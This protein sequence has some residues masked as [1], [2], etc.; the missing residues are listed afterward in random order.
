MTTR[1]IYFNGE[2]KKNILQLSSN[3]M[4]HV[5]RKL[6]FRICEN[7]GADQLRG[8]READQGLCFR[9]IDNTIPLLPMYEIS[10][11]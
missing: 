5:V 1:N 7:K 10:S 4:S 9:Y 2:L 3:I 8:N 6:A 11:L